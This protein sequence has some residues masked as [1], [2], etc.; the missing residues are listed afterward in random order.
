[1][2]LSVTIAHAVPVQAVAS[3][4]SHG[5]CWK[6]S[7]RIVGISY[8]Q[9][10]REPGTDAGTMARSQGSC[11]PSKKSGI[12]NYRLHCGLDR[13]VDRTLHIGPSSGVSSSA[14]GRA[15]GVASAVATNGTERHCGVPC[16]GKGVS[17]SRLTNRLPNSNT[18]RIVKLF[19][20]RPCR[21]FNSSMRRA[22]DRV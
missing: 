21:T 2:T 19:N 11:T 4:Y 22:D 9:S 8:R 10:S 17:H 20:C 5:A 7:R 13:S 1:M 15:P 3:C 18:N 16:S 14:L 12:K 6:D